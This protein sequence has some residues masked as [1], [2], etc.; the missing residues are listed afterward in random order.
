[1]AYGSPDVYH[2][3]EEFGLAQV[4]DIDY[5]TGSYEFDMRVVWRHTDTGVLYTA[6]DSGCSCPSPFEDYMSIEQLE[7]ASLAELRAEVEAEA[8]D[9]E[10]G[11]PN[12]T[13]TEGNDFLRAVETAQTT[14]KV[15]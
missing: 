9:R 2:Q 7:R 8:R 10:Y 15:G 1:M 14:T 11:T 13:M 5:S 3:P 6:R 4:A 12:I